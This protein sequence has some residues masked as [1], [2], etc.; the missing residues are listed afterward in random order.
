ME[1]QLSDA[2]EIATAEAM[3]ASADAHEAATK[4]VL[5]AMEGLIAAG[6]RVHAR[7][8]NEAVVGMVGTVD[9]LRQEGRAILHRHGYVESDLKKASK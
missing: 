1:T 7:K 6:Y 5:E 9:A 2:Q 3:L 8:L 4:P